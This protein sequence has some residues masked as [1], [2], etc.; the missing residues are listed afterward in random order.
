MEIL[1]IKNLTKKYDKVEVLRN[2]NMH[3]T[4]GEIYGLIGKN[5]AGKTTLMKAILGLTDIAGGEIKLWG[6]TISNM[7]SLY[8]VNAK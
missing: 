7:P 5:G 6:K 3:V 1:T 4:E 2:I 8:N